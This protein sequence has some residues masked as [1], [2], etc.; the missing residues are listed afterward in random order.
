VREG[1][2]I[3]Y[4]PSCWLRRL[5]YSPEMRRAL[6]AECAAFDLVHLHSVYLW[7]TWAAARAARHSKTPYLLAP[8]GMLVKK[9]IER[10]SA[11][12]KKA[13]IRFIERRNIEDAAGIHVTSSAEA[14][15]LRHFG[16]RL[17][18]VY[19]VPNGVATAGDDESAQALP[20]EVLRILESGRPVILSLGRIHW[21]KGLDRLIQA[22]ARVPG[23]LLLVAGNDEE[24]Y[25]PELASL[26]TDAGVR[27]RVIFAEAVYGAAK[28]TLYRRA[29][30][31]ALA[32][33]SENFGNTVLEAMAEGCPV[34]VTPEVGAARIVEMA[35]GGLV[36]P[37][38]PGPF[39][40]A[41]RRLLT[42]PKLRD[43]FGR[44]GQ[45]WVREHYSWDRVAEQMIGA[46]KL[47]VAHGAE[48]MA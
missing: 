22:L 15:D 2:T 46:Y 37:G 4:F 42:E 3:R 10:E 8:R 39:A 35:G 44:R 48:G 14:E 45:A 21:K 36:A 47:L 1:V 19:E 13:W 18:A 28:A 25:T 5:Y 32:S 16:F 23:A 9:L 38:E 40:D 7:P 11:V 17:P 34:V 33:Y 30:I 43:E 24:G 41:L 12:A 26:A 27:E 29:A 31:F 6:E 20:P